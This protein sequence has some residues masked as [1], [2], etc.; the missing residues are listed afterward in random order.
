MEQRQKEQTHPLNGDFL[1][2][3]LSQNKQIQLSPTKYYEIKTK[4]LTKENYN[5]EFPGNPVVRI[6]HFYC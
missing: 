4:K 5:M 2:L 6:P 1:F 3:G